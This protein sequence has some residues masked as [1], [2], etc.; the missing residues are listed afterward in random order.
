MLVFQTPQAVRCDVVLAC[1][2]ERVAHS[3]NDSIT[4]G[5]RMLLL[6]KLTL[7]PALV[8]AVT[9]ASRRWGLRVAGIVTGL[10]LVAGPTF[11]FLA[12][13]QGPAFAADAARAAI[14][15]VI[16]T[17]AFCVAYAAAAARVNWM[18]SVVAGWL[19]F[20][21]VA[22][23]LN[24]LPP[25]AGVGELLLSWAGLLAASR[26]LP[27]P[28]SIQAAPAKPP[29][30]LA[31]RMVSAGAAV[32]VF[33]GLAELLGPRVSGLLSVFPI[34]T[35]ILA[36]FTHAQSGPGAAAIFLRGL[37]RGMYGLTMFCLVFTAA[38]GLLRWP[39]IAAMSAALAVQIALQAMMLRR[40]D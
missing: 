38:L 12:I 40:S 27:A 29:A 23:V 31:V 4:T 1:L 11:A 20:A 21:A 5:P 33:T 34:V 35:A 30:D 2:R 9:L 32:V 7:V 16:A 3:P 18:G 17:S 8:A 36:M 25:F 28:A 15:G 6:L 13:E 14:L 10:P 19:A 24:G 22:L 37:L 39:L 26:L